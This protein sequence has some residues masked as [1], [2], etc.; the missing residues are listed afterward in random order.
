MYFVLHIVEYALFA[1]RQYIVYLL[2]LIMPL[3]FGL[4]T[5]YI[6]PIVLLLYFLKKKELHIRTLVFVLALMALEYIHYPFYD[7]EAKTD[8]STMLNYFS[9]WFIVAYYIFHT[10]KEV[11]TDKSL[12]WFCLARVILCLF[13]SWHSIMIFDTTGYEMDEVR[14]GTVGM[15]GDLEDGKIFLRANPNTLGYYSETAISLLLIQIIRK[16]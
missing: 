6:F 9:A 3:S 2:A 8:L 11:D 13:V 1:P 5:G 16:K 4:S 14:L 15:K 12:F 10:D 7:Y